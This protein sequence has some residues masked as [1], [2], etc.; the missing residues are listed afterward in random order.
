MIQVIDAARP[1]PAVRQIERRTEEVIAIPIPR[2]LFCIELA[3]ESREIVDR[4]G[5]V[6]FADIGPSGDRIESI[7]PS[8]AGNR[9]E[10]VV[11]Q[12]KFAGKIVVGGEFILVVVPMT[13]SRSGSFR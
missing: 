6:V 7:R 3:N 9:S 13:R 8:G 1:I 11:A 5:F 4:D 12:N 2:N 10:P